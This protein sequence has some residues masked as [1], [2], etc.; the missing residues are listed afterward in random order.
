MKPIYLAL[1]ICLLLT[2]IA[3]GQMSHM[4]RANSYYPQEYG[5]QPP[6]WADNYNYQPQY[7]PTM[8]WQSYGPVYGQHDGYYGYDLNRANYNSQG[9]GQWWQYAPS[10]GWISGWGYQ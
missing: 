9:M 5:F 4:S 6:G 1:A 10:S 8:Y 2:G 3:V 7:H